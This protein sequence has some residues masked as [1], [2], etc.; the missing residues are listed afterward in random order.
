MGAPSLQ[1]Y[2]SLFGLTFIGI[3][4]TSL[5]HFI[6]VG[7]KHF[8][9]ELTILKIHRKVPLNIHWTFPV[10]IHWESDNPLEHTTEMLENATDHPLENAADNPQ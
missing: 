3:S 2:V 10:E 5:Q 1:A 6:T 8:T 7:A 9:P 4:G